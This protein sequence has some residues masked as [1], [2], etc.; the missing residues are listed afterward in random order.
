M[1]RSAVSVCQSISHAGP[2]HRLGGR[3]EAI[4]TCGIGAVRNAF[5]CFDSVVVNAASFAEGSFGYDVIRFLRIQLMHKETAG[6]SG[7]GQ[8]FQEISTRVGKNS[9]D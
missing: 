6:N 1:L 9:R 7:G 3:H 5:E 2:I 4:R 8:V